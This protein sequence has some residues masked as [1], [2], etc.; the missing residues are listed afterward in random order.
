MCALETVL[1]TVLKPLKT[2]KTSLPLQ[3]QQYLENLIKDGTY[4]PGEQLPSQELL[5]LQLGI[6]RATLREALQKL[7]IEGVI[8]RR[9]GVGTFV[10]PNYRQRLDTGLEV[11]E[12][13]EQIASKSGLKAHMSMLQLDVYPARPAEQEKLG[14]YSDVEILSVSRVMLLDDRPVAHLVDILPTHFL[15]TMDLQN[16]FTGSVLDILVR[17]G[18][19]LLSYSYTQIESVP[20]SKDLADALMVHRRAPLLKFE[21]RLYERDGQVVDFSVSHFVPG[22]FNFHVVRR[23]GN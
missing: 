10:S 20:A 17:L 2:A 12:S 13:L 5:A 1:S 9:H 8:Q 22:H 21:G 23:I 15:K 6:S 16:G 7:E 14:L 4:Q 3:T 19:P 18:H 11:L